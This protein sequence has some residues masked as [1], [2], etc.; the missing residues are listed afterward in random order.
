MSA[1]HKP[2]QVVV[3]GTVQHLAQQLRC[4]SATISESSRLDTHLCLV[5]IAEVNNFYHSGVAIATSPSHPEPQQPAPSDSCHTS[6]VAIATSSM[7][8]PSSV[9][10]PNTSSSNSSSGRDLLSTPAHPPGE[11]LADSSSAV[12]LEVSLTH[13]L[14]KQGE[15]CIEVVRKQHL[16]G[17]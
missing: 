4:S 1:T 15:N 3:S 6:G 9:P 13:Y 10:H 2:N 14:D 5:V 12:W 16:L 7:P 11:H 17:S 8:H